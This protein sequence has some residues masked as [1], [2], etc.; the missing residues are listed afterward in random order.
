MKLCKL[1]LFFMLA[2]LPISGGGQAVDALL[3]HDRLADNWPT[4]NGD[5]SGRRFSSLTGIN[6]ST[7]KNLK[8]AWTYRLN[9]SAGP[10]TQTGGE[11]PAPGDGTTTDPSGRIVKASPLMVNGVLFFATPDHVW[12]IDARDGHELWHFMWHTL[13]GVHVGNRGVGMYGSWLFFSTP[14]GYLVS[15]D[16]KTGMERWHKKIVDF[17][18][19]YYLSVAPIVIENHVLVG[20][21]GDLLDVHRRRKRVEGK[22][23]GVNEADSTRGREP[24]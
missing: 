3:L 16:A 7:I 2:F 14:D 6:Q 20:T 9:T 12:A 17:K 10:G 24:Q 22:A 18:L 15:L 8:P 19:G 23:A 4:F 21:S 11:G 5:Y 1:S 13:G